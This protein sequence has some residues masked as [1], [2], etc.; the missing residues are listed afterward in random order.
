MGAAMVVKLS[1]EI[2]PE[3]EVTVKISYSTTSQC[4]AIGWLEKE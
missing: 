4:T 3:T 1:E 2:A